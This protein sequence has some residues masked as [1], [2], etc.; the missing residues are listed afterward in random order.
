MNPIVL[1]LVVG[2]ISANVINTLLAASD[3]P[4]RVIN[5]QIDEII[6]GTATKVRLYVEWDDAG[7]RAALPQ[8]LVLK[9][10]FGPHRA[11]MAYIYYIEERFYREVQP[12]LG[13]A[14]PRC[15]GSIAGTNGEQALVLLEDLDAAGAH[16]CR[17]VDPISPDLTAQFLSQLAQMHAK[18]W[19]VSGAVMNEVAKL[20]TWQALPMDDDGAYARGQLAEQVWN[21]AMTLPRS[22]A[23]S[24]VFH[25]RSAMRRSLERIDAYTR[26]KVQCLLHADFHL[27]NLYLTSEG[28]P[29]VL[30]WQSLSSGHWS[31]DVTYFMISAL[32]QRDRRRHAK[33]LLAFYLDKLRSFGV[34][35]T[36]DMEQALEAFRIQ[37]A[38]GLFYWMV[39]P[40]EWQSEENNCA[41]APRFAD[42]ALDFG[43]FDDI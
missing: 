15:F 42:A 38:D 25:D 3:S 8:N 27:G 5:C 43:T 40:P 28:V 41:V 24:R 14:S 36:P 13:I 12:W 22:L 7:Q 11:A 32:D 6:Y 1:P 10:G 26:D 30:D 17:V 35:D 29:S 34:T 39:N 21:R 18:T 37:I 33:E 9:G 4:A 23:V 16:F 20:N 31:H 19:R 2:D